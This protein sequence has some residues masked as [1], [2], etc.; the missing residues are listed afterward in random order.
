M[1]TFL[2]NL[3]QLLRGTGMVLA[4]TL[5]ILVFVCAVWYG[6]AVFVD[7]FPDVFGGTFIAIVFLCCGGSYAKKQN[8]FK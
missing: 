6:L 8:W 4:V 2:Y 7:K 1:K 5:T 3:L